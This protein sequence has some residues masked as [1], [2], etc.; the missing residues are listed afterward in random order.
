MIHMVPGTGYRVAFISM[1]GTWYST[2]YRLPGTRVPGIL[3][4]RERA[5]IISLGLLSPATARQ[6]GRVAITV[7]RT[8]YPGTRYGVRSMDSGPLLLFRI[9]T[10]HPV[11]NSRTATARLRG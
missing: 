8:G 9:R 2:R 4:S 10:Y 5:V 6:A 3:F 1:T 7:D 11:Q